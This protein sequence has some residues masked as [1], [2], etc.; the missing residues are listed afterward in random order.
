MCNAARKNDFSS[1]KTNKILELIPQLDRLKNLGINALY[2][3]PLFESTSHGYDT[4]DYYYIDRRLGNNDDFKLF[5]EECHKRD[6]CLVV[7]TVFNHTGRDFFAFK[8][9]QQNGKDSKYLDW[10]KN[11]R[12][13]SKSPY[14]DNFTYEGWAGCMDL[15]KLNTDNPQVREHLFGAVKKWVEE[16]HI[17]GLRMDAADLLTPS[18]LQA[19]RQFCDSLNPD[20]WLMGEVVHGDYNNWVNPKALDSVTNYQIYKGLWSSFNSQNMFECAWNLNEQFGPNGK[21]KILTLY[22]F[23][24]NHDVNR[25]ASTVSKQEYLFPL[26]GMLFTIPGIPSIYYGSEF[27]LRG[28]RNQYDDFQLRPPLPPFINDYQ[29]FSKPWTDSNALEKAI[30]KFAQIRQ[31]HNALKKG[32]YHQLAV[33]NTSLAFKRTFYGEEIIVLINQSDSEN[34]IKVQNQSGKWKDLLNDEYFDGKE[35]EKIKVPSCWL[36]ILI[37]EF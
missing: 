32:D 36:R 22:S 10:Y 24:D 17:D 27:A 16:F 11:I 18:F 15:V 6:I 31:K 14:G 5:I 3:G 26:Y 37:K 33:T 13:D 23:L 1:P 7:D 25:I 4:V 9:L 21:Y 12:F 34:I 2:I 8:D 28:Q 30:I 35:L 29:D 19:L 20:L